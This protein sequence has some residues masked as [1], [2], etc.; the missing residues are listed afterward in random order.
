MKWR[1]WDTNL[2]I[3]LLGEG[4]INLLFWMFFPFM[5]IYFS[6]AFGKSTAGMLLVISQVI[7]VVVGLIGGYCADHFG[8]KRMMVIAG[9]GQALAFI[10]FALGVSPW[11][12]SP[13]LAFLAF[14]A[15]GLF[16]Q[17]YWPASHAMI[18][19][20][21]NEK[22][23]SA[24][25]AVFY[26]STNITVVIGPLLGGIFFFDYRFPFII[27]CLLASLALAVVLQR[28][29]RETVPVGKK[30][31]E[32]METTGWL[33]YINRQLSDYK[34]IT[35]DRLF[36]LFIIA[37]ILVAQTF[38]QLDLLIA[39]YTTDQVPKQTLFSIGGWSLHITGKEAFSAIVSEN[40]LI[41][42]LFTVFMTRWMTKYKER[43]VFILSSCFYGIG[44][45]IFGHTLNIWIMFLAM[46]IFTC[47]EIMV[48]GIQD[49][50]ISKLAPEHIRGQYFAA[51]SLRFSIGRTIAPIAIPLSGWVG[52]SWTFMI[53]GLLAFMSAGLYGI[54]F[55][56]FEKRGQ[57][58]HHMKVVK[59]S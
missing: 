23:R 37:G 9:Y 15:L 16:G 25:F 55:T 5:A 33:S 14:S 48:V 7:S 31:N 12:H 57:T 18:A 13:M 4:V 1:D 17:L 35:K 21:V 8:R 43:R 58:A 22:H 20:V 50:F 36:L 47:A 42:V 46:A 40:G 49:A 29:L 10:P 54:M 2:K 53:L 11:V 27:V 34:I 59:S 6:D 39:V 45:M 28:F 52:Y 19:D 51:S 26:T 38:M 32:E 41:V 30:A 44:I 56:Q 24:I 3:R